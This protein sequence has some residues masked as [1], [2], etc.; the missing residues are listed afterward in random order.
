VEIVAFRLTPGADLKRELTRIVAERGIRA[1]YIVSCVGSLARARLRMPGA[2]GEPDRFRS[3]DE[4]T[5]IISL[6]G[7]LCPDGLHL[8]IAVA[9]RDG[10]C[11][12]GHLVDGCLVHTTAE[13]IVGELPELEFQRLLDP[14]TG[15]PE[16]RIARRRQDPEA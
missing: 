3:F 8:H 10:Q 2:A 16:L 11:I 14:E 4:P 5:E 6:A 12:A 15:Y 7:T 1:G 13:V 9:D